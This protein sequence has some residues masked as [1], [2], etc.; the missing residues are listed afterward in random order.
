MKKLILK[1]TP[2]LL[3]GLSLT[4]S[5]LGLMTYL[6]TETVHAAGPHHVAPSCAGVPAPCYTTVQAAVD[7]ADPG[8][9]IMVAAGTY[10]GVTSRAGVTQTV[11]ISKSVTIRGGYTTAFTEPPD[12][13]T[14]PTTLDA[15]GQGRVMYIIGNIT[16]TIEGLQITGG[17]TNNAGGDNWEI[18]GNGGGV[19]AITASLTFKNNQVIGNTALDAG[20]ILL[21]R[22]SGL[23]SD[24]IVIGNTATWASGGVCLYTSEAMLWGNTIAGN[25]AFSGGG[26]Y[27][28][29]NSNATLVNN[30]IAENFATSMGSG[31]Y[32]EGS[33]AKL[34]QTT[35]VQNAPGD[36]IGIFVRD[37]IGGSST[38][39]LTNTILVSQTIGISVTGGSKAIL[40]STLWNNNLT[41][42]AG[43]GIITAINNYTG[44]PAL[45]APFNYPNPD[46]HLA[47]T[48]AAI[49]KGINAG[50]ATD[51][52]GQPRPQGAGF[53]LGAD[54]YSAPL[55]PLTGVTINGPLT[56]ALNE[57]YPFSAT[58]T[59]TTATPPVTYTWAPAPESGQGTASVTYTWAVTGAKTITV[60]AA[61]AGGVVTDTH[62]IG[63]NAPALSLRKSGPT[64]A[65]PGNLI[66]YTLTVTNSGNLTA[67]NLIITDT[68]P[69]NATY[70]NG[71]TK[72]GNVVSWTIPSLAASGGVTQTTFVVTATQTITNSD[73]GVR[74]DGG[75]PAQGSVAVVTA[76]NAQAP[77]SKVF[78]PVIL[79]Q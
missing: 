56:G 29:Y 44:D 16:P 32:V 72:V 75:Y 68:I 79:K 5:L 34:M 60:T 54:E 26:I 57:S 7:A 2:A 42:W 52:D 36:R 59:P 23:L 70:I 4:L 38:A 69:P 3:F 65:A 63:I 67:T 20:G 50:V 64:A 66:T 25:A 21:L 17:N 40:E 19:A 74:A 47:P 15:Q 35:F 12:P 1:L 62:L 33:S 43:T 14:N 53:D 49:D 58:F 41:N 78:V 9:V 45:V 11:Y 51:I 77:E 46:Y 8:D 18:Q 10:T 24:N 61:H 48:S 27:I 13:Q 39:I 73:Y 30:F 6:H 71:G 22:S 55:V 28:F 31:V 76:I 37:G